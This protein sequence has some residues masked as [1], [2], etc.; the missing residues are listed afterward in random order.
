[1]AR[2]GITFKAFEHAHHLLGSIARLLMRL[3]TVRCCGGGHRFDEVRRFI[4][5]PQDLCASDLFRKKFQSIYG[6]FITA[7]WIARQWRTR[8]CCDVTNCFNGVSMS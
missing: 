1:M 8:F 2:C 7:S 4:W 3:G 5:R 6:G